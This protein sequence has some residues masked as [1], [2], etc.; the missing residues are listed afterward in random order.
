MIWDY[1]I[2]WYAELRA[3][4]NIGEK[5]VIDENSIAGADELAAYRSVGLALEVP[6]ALSR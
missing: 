4:R 6:D 2:T 5:G 3:V 1:K